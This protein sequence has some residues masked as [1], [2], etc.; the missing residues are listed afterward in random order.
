VT[1]ATT[2]LSDSGTTVIISTVNKSMNYHI[3][4]YAEQRFRNAIGDLKADNLGFGRGSGRTVEDIDI[5]TVEG[6]DEGLRILDEALDQV[7]KTRSLLGAATNRLE[8]T[9]S[10]L[11]VT[12][13]NLTASYS[14]L[15]DA[16]IARE[17]TEFTKNQVLLQAGT[18]VLA[19]ANYIQQSFLSLLG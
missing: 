6:V 5:T 16:D 3:G 8:A 9:V 4:A 10:N 18:S 11:S 17:S 7:N 2:G 15:K 1:K 13:E 19:Q 14:R 12:S